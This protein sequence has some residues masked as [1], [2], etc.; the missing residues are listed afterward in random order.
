MGGCALRIPDSCGG[1][2]GGAVGG[3]GEC[4]D[5]HCNIAL[6]THPQVNSNSP[7]IASDNGR[8]MAPPA[9]LELTLPASEAG[10]L[11]N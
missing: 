7:L 11:S 5:V 8:K 10:A 3:C 4:V 6:N 9:R 2:F 1:I